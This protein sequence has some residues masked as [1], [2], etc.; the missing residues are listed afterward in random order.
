[1]LA[2]V[3]E[4]TQEIGILRAFGARRAEVIAQFA[5]EASALCVAGGVVGVPLGAVLSAGVALAAGWPV[6]VSTSAVLLALGLAAAVGL[7]FG[8]YPARVAADVAPI[9]ALRAP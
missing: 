3:A 8:I 9:E 4:R 5:L 2:S 6:A 7:L 1:M